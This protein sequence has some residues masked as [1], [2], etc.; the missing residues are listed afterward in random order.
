L[1]ARWAIAFLRSGDNFSARAF[2]PFTPPSFPRATAA[3]FFFGLVVKSIGF[4]GSFA[5]SGAPIASSTALSAFY[6]V[7]LLLERLRIDGIVTQV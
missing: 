6:A 5:F 1:A 7:S 2:P 3:G 4:L